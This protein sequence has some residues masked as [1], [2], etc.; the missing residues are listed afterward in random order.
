MSSLSLFSEYTQKLTELQEA[1]KLAKK[2]KWGPEEDAKNHVRDVKW[3]IENPR[4]FVD[5][6]KQ[7]PQKAV[8][9]QVRDGSTVRA[10]LLPDFYYITLVMSGVKVNFPHHFRFK[11]AAIFK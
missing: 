11:F 5:S 2:G 6:L 7:K 1:A 4:N 8:I 9:E 10:F 3:T